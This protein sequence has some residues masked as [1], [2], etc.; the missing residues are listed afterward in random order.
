MPVRIKEENTTKMSGHSK[1]HS[2]RH[3][4]AKE[5]K[6]RGK[7]FSKL[8]R[9]ITVAAREGGGDPDFNFRLRRAIE[10]AKDANMPKENIDK[11]IKRGTGELEGVDYIEKVY[12]GYGPGGVAVIVNVTTDNKNRAVTQIRK[13]F[14][15]HDGSLGENGCVSWMFKRRGFITIEKRLI[16]EDSLMEKLI[17]LGVKELNVEDKYYEI[18]TEVDN[19]SEVQ[20]KLKNFVSI[21]SA[22]LTMIPNT[23]IKLTGKEAE[24]ML[25]MM[26]ALEDN[27]DVQKVFAN[28]DIPT[29]EVQKIQNEKD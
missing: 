23:Y 8:V 26:D 27:D 11:A 21:D 15:E 12:E 5:D 9:E 7:L 16:D 3:Q 20:E 2:I 6:K 14:N 29:E 13:I 1:W 4:K 24:T 19:F 18:M 28:F 25:K 22:E 10:R 17:E